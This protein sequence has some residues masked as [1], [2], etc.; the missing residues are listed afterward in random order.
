MA[1][2]MKITSQGRNREVYVKFSSF[3]IFQLS[4]VLSVCSKLMQL[5]VYWLLR[6]NVYVTFIPSELQQT[7]LSPDDHTKVKMRCRLQNLFLLLGFL[8]ILLIILL[9]I[10]DGSKSRFKC[11]ISI[12][13]SLNQREW[14][15]QYLH[16]DLYHGMT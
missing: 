4:F 13:M 8:L 1:G 3:A 12:C 6:Y 9:L 14:S 2:K 5:I 7:S 11:N 10:N 16:N 15:L